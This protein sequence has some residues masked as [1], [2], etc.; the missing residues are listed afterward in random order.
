M[1]DSRVKTTQTKIQDSKL[2]WE[3]AND[4]KRDINKIL[5]VLDFP[6]V[7][8]NRI[9]CYR[10]QGSKSRSYARI[11][12]FPKIFQ[13]ALELEPAYVIE[14]LA[15][16]YD[17][18][19]SNEKIKVLIHELLHIPRNFSGALVPHVTR[20]RHL[21]RTANALFNEYQENLRE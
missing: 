4:V 13:D 19:D 5:K 10:T 18:L 20:S 7:K 3:K 15:K 11:W 6:Y 8:A 16:H 21:G 2:G 17:K 12:S 9:F 1:R 14:V